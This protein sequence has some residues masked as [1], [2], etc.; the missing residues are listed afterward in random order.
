[1]G[2]FANAR[3]VAVAAWSVAAVIVGLNLRLLAYT[4]P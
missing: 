1:M 3:W 4:F 2:A